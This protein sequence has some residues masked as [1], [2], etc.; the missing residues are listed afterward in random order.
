MLG[1][2]LLHRAL[3]RA[4]IEESIETAAALTHFLRAIITRTDD[5]SYAARLAGSQSSAVLSAMARAN[6]LL[7]VPAQ[8]RSNPAG[9]ILDALPLTDVISMSERF[10]IQ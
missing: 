2:S 8:A 7:I 5:G 4:R 1:H 10:A 3:V 9:T 6:A